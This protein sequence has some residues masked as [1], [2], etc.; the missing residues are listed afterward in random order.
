M[1]LQRH[2]PPTVAPHDPPL[3]PAAS[4]V[5]RAWQLLAST[6]N[7]PWIRRII[8]GGLVLAGFWILRGAVRSSSVLEG[9]SL[10][11]IGLLGCW[12][13]GIFLSLPDTIPA[14]N[15]FVSGLFTS[16][17]LPADR[18][19][20]L[21]YEFA[22]RMVKRCEYAVATREY[23]KI[24]EFYPKEFDA[25]REL[26]QVGLACDDPDFAREILER[27]L[28]RL[29]ATQRAALRSEFPNLEV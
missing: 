6:K 12:M 25:Y 3:P 16:V 20:P 8:A 4:P 24:L 17:Y 13:P 28:K 27:A 22:R 14:A 11:I 2:R 5:L 21:D 26:I 15:R 9:L 29:N 18:T 7:L 19:P 1:R 10:S 23:L